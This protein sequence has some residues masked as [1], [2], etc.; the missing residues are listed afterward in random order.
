[1]DLLKQQ[2]A[3]DVRSLSAQLIVSAMTVRQHLYTLLKE[4][5]VTFT[6]LV[7]YDLTLWWK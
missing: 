1:M 4:K 5:L 7:T 6:R 3:A 2:G